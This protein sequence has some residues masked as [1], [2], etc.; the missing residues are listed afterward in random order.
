MW[1]LRCGRTESAEGRTG[2]S[3]RLTFWL[4]RDSGFIAE[5]KGGW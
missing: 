5:D 3:K 2:A 1:E 4:R